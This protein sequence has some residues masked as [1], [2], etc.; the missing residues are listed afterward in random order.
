MKKILFLI[1]LFSSSVAYAGS[2]DAIL[3]CKSASGRTIFK[4]ALQDLVA[5][6]SAEFSIDGEKLIYTDDSKGHLVF[7][8]KNKVLTLTINDAE[9]GWLTFYAI[10]TTF[11]TV[12]KGHHS[13]HYKFKAVIQGKDPRKGKYQSKEI[14]LDCELT[15]SV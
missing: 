6:T 10:P 15:Y 3:T 8:A 5:F 4:A 9:V 2:A 11:K 12:S 7:N 13:A 14:T 1:L